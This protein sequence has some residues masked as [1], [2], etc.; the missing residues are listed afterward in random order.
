MKQSYFIFFDSDKI[1]ILCCEKLRMSKKLKRFKQLVVGCRIMYC[2]GFCNKP[3][4][5]RVSVTVTSFI[6]CFVEWVRRLSILTL[7]SLFARARARVCVCD[8]V[9][10][11]W[12]SHIFIIEQC[13]DWLKLCSVKSNHP[14]FKKQ[15]IHADGK[16]PRTCSTLRHCMLRRARYQV[17]A[18]L[19]IHCLW[20]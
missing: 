6:L 12:R 8:Y 15:Y 9:P 10:S 19:L 3:R 18:S 16:L 4:S 14:T 5:E 2:I 1:I 20:L 7:K 11:N 13:T 17:H